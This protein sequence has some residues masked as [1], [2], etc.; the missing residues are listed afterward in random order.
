[1]PWKGADV[2][3]IFIAYVG[4]VVAGLAYFITIGLLQR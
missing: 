1:V 2:R 3:G 4:M